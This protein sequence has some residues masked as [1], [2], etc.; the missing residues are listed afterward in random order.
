MVELDD[1]HSARARIRPHLHRTPLIGSSYLDSRLG[2]HVRIKAESLQKTGSYKPRGVLNRVA[3]LSDEERRR[4]VVTV[5]AGNHAQAAAFACARESIPCAVVMPS[6]A[7]GVKI[8]ATR[9]YGATVVLHDDMRSLFQRCEEVREQRQA[10]F[11]HPF[12]HPATVAGTGTVGLEILEDF[13]EVD[14]VIC[15]VGGGGLICGIARSMKLLAPS[16]RVIGVEP[17]GAPTMTRALE[18]GEPVQLESIDTIADGL[19]APF[20]GALNLEIVQQDVDAVVLVS[21]DDILTA[22][23]VYFDRMKLVVEPAGAAALGA[24][25]AGKVPAPGGNVCI[26]ASG[27]NVDLIQYAGWRQRH[28]RGARG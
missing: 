22:M 13:P 21:D 14:T 4:G 11:V 25:L 18:A 20:A 28:E 12:D 26:V 5:S 23:R 24:L 27:G 19:S 16:V 17:I 15:G 7:P 10:T 8:E 1:I 6:T 9:D 3:E 2:I